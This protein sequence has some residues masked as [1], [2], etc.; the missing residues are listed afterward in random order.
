M[1][2]REY[3]GVFRACPTCKQFLCSLPVS[4]TMLPLARNF[5]GMNLAADN[6][7]VALGV[8][9]KNHGTK[10]SSFPVLADVVF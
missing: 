4:M 5:V 3:H 6:D 2:K 10:A 8:R 7:A 1:A 9:E